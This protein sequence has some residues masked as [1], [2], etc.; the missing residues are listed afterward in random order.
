M[1][2][3]HMEFVKQP[4]RY[5]ITFRAYVDVDVQEQKERARAARE[6][7]MLAVAPPTSGRRQGPRRFSRNMIPIRDESPELEVAAIV[8]DPPYEIEW[9]Q[10][11]DATGRKIFVCHD[12]RKI[13][14]PHYDIKFN[15]VAGMATNGRIE[16][17]GGIGE[18]DEIEYLRVGVPFSIFF[19]FE[20]A[21]GNK[22]APPQN[23]EELK[24]SG[25]P[26]VAVAATRSA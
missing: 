24:C 12:G 26:L 19:A 9:Q 17:I 5:V 8:E 6:V 13:R 2:L 1:S 15:V 7:P 22:A 18:E 11:V 21:K 4:G 10:E 16:R 20:D 23:V 14:M 25:K 3:K